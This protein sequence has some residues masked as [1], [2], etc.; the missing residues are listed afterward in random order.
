MSRWSATMLAVLAGSGI[1]LWQADTARDQARRAQQ[2]AQV[3][4]TEA[5]AAEAVESFMEAIFKTNSSDQSDPLKAR[6]TTA[7]ELLDI[8]ASKIDSSL[9]DAP[10]AR[11]RVL[12]TL[13]RMY[14]ELGIFEQAIVLRR[15]TVDVARLQIGTD[16]ELAQALID[17]STSLNGIEGSG[18]ERLRAI[19]EAQQILDRRKDF[20]SRTRGAL[21]AERAAYARDRDHAEALEQAGLAVKILR[22]FPPTMDLAGALELQAETLWRQ[23]AFEQAEATAAEGISITKRVV[24]D[25]NSGLPSLYLLLAESQ[26]AGMK[27]A[28]AEQSHRLAW[29]AAR[30]VFGDDHHDSIETELWLGVFLFSRSKTEEGLRLIADSVAR[31][32]RAGNSGDTLIMASTRLAY[33]A[34]LARHGSLEKGLAL[35]RDV[36]DSRRRQRSAPW[37]L[38]KALEQEVDALIELGR[39]DLATQLLDE[40]ATTHAQM[41]TPA[42]KRNGILLARARILIATGHAS[43][44]L[45][46]IEAWAGEPSDSDDTLM[47]LL[48]LAAARLEDDSPQAAA[49]MA[50]AVRL[51]IAANPERPYLMNLEAEASLI[52]GEALCRQ[53]RAGDAL[54]LLQRAVALSEALYDRRSSPR[55]AQAQIA[56][57]DCHLDRGD[58]VH[59]RALL[60][61]ARDI[62][63]LHRELGVPYTRPLENLARRL[64]A[65]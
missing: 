33:G 24:G 17:L 37:G 49:N 14:E 9:Q 41:G 32:S 52:E 39:Y 48:A 23:G 53:Q 25:H 56:L 51:K 35:I 7:R 18:D 12:A 34:A 11:L 30:T 44:A 10:A 58:R 50:S 28:A 55:L 61:Q 26:N 63:A 40:A 21:H 4:R 65:G 38:V 22:N 46:Q 29:Q 1:A 13:A 2:Q 6:H 19:T 60:E 36:A 43:D 5:R 16:T 54:P 62:H 45:Q 8:G 64:K 31:A 15:K 42:P 57:G 20:A 3:A 27:L 47:R 59:A